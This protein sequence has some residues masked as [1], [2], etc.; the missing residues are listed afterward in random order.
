MKSVYSTGE[1]LKTCNKNKLNK[2]QR[3]HRSPE[4]IFPINKQAVH[5]ISL[6]KRTKDH[7]FLLENLL[8]WSSI[9]MNLNPKLRQNPIFMEKTFKSH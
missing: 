6:V 2:A 8:H 5:S 9:C 7:Y 3:P 4:K 1:K